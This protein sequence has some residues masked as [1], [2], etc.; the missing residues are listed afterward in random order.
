MTIH[1]TLMNAQIYSDPREFRPQRWIQASEDE[2]ERMSRSY[3]PFS[4]GSRM[5]L[6]I[7]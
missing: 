7:K 6:G 1:K 5:C 2:L 4:R 3:V